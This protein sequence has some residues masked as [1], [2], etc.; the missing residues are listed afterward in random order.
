MGKE[1]I[2][3]QGFK[4]G[5]VDDIAFDEKSWSIKAFKIKLEKDIAERHN[6]KQLFRKSHVLVSVGHVQAVG[7]RVLLKSSTEEIMRLITFPSSVN[8]EPSSA[9]AVPQPITG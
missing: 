4:L 6:M 3:A 7:D 5:K 9:Q 8:Q 1:V 2:S